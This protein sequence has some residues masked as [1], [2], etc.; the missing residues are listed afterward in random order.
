M[1]ELTSKET[2]QKYIEVMG[3]ELG[4]IFH[5][6]RNELLW[7]FEK[8][9]EYVELFGTKQSR[10]ELVNQAASH[11]FG[12][13][14]NTLW[15]NTLLHIARITDN[16]KSAGKE[17]LT[18]RRLPK[19]IEKQSCKKEVEALIDKIN[20]KRE[21][22]KDWRDR[23]IAHSDLK[24][25]IWEDA[26]KLKPA[27]RKQVIELL[28]LIAKALNTVSGY[29]TDSTIFFEGIG[30]INGSV[31]LLHV[32]DDGLRAKKKRLEDIEKNVYDPSNLSPRYL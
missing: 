5:A 17:N 31:S 13:V 16:E 6:L 25:A 8:W 21:F 22:C 11:F 12:I 19:L 27:S 10:V 30:N 26:E 15:E 18:I 28:K 1:N 9:T 4:I 2:K 29:Y 32:I 20:K 7:L 23:H 14:Q 24:L 3:K